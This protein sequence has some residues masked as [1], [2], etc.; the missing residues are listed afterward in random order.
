MKWHDVVS[1]QESKTGQADGC[2]A[3]HPKSLMPLLGICVRQQCVMRCYIISRNSV[4]SAHNCASFERPPALPGGDR[5]RVSW[6]SSHSTLSGARSRLYQRRFSRP[7]THFSAFFKI[8]KKIIFS[9][10]NFA[11]FCKKEAKI[12]KIL[13]FFAKKIFFFKNFR[14]T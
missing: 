8:F 1:N 6:N 2:I 4:L 14:N 10:A 7:N 13:T 12:C 11:N 5:S 9:R 3:C